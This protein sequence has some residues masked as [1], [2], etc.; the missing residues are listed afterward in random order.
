MKIA[1]A[2][3]V[4]GTDNEAKLLARCLENMS[5][6]VDGIFITRTHKKG[7]EPNEAVGAVARAYNAHLSDFEWVNDFA[8]ARNFNFSQVPAEYGYIMW[9]DA[10]DLWRGLGKLRATLQKHKSMDAFGFWYL[11]DWDEFKKPIVVHKKT[12]VIK[13]DGCA[14]WVGALHEDLD[15]TR[16][17]E[18][19]LVEGIDRLHISS[20]E[21]A[22]ENARRNVEIAKHQ[23]KLLPDDPRSYWNLG[24]S[25][26]GIADYK[27][28][29]RSFQHFIDT[30]ESDTEK[31]LVYMRLSDVCKAQGQS[32]E[33][34]KYLRIAIGLNPSI[35]DAYLQM[36]HLYYTMG[37]W[38]KAEHYCLEGLVK[39]PLIHS[40]IVYNPRDYDYNP[41]MLLARIYY[42]KNR[43]DLMLPMLKG[44]LKI[45]PDD[46]KLKNLV[47]EG[48]QD[49]KAMEAALKRVEKLQSIT[50]KE[51]LRKELAKLPTSIASH[52][53]ISVLRNQN[54]IKETS[55]GR[56]F[57]FYCGNTNQ[58]WNPETFKTEGVGGSEEAVINLS[59]ELAKLG[60]NV[61]VY[62][63]CGNR[64]AVETYGVYPMK[65]PVTITYRPFWEFN[66]RDKQDVVILWRWVKPLDIDIN[67]PKIF[68]DLHDVIPSGEF[69]EKRLARVSKI[70]V[71]TQFHRSLFPNV[72]DDKIAIIPNGIDFTLLNT[73]DIEKD[74]YLMINT[75]SP[76]R[77]MDVLPKLFREVKK[78]VP[79]ARLQWAYGWDGFKAAHS[80][81]TKKMKWMRDTQREMEDAGIETLGRITQAE[82]GKLY[83]RAAI[84]AYPTEF[85][86]IDCISVK[87]AQAAGAWVVS[88]DFGALDESVQWGLKVHS[89]KTKETWNRPYQFHFGLEDE[90][91]QA[92]WVA[93]C[94]AALQHGA[95]H[96][97]PTMR[98]FEWSRI[99]ARW[100]DIL[101]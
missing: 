43:P 3:I 34:I 53:A 45:Y 39:R 58:I 68:V 62:N 16:Q 8:A 1:L 88:S 59:R 19:F 14:K 54:F 44:C 77:S 76:D 7:E 21:R 101:T 36:A 24:N 69:N 32:D 55:T 2:M 47:R 63:N 51:K 66:Y 78:R 18:T 9:S 97:R 95:M 80:G 89:T 64:A 27:A 30:S 61:T 91:A 31:Y 6:Y 84:F 22:A 65:R 26:L 71:K 98:E 23:A 79:Q 57:V 37:N 96:T 74:P 92:D 52:P 99:A 93:A 94:V 85:A 75:S 60:W 29:E 100:H 5:P 49:Y 82:V 12:M 11:Y 70:F 72:P 50:D 56:D 15:P 81:D 87:K 10:D 28:A 40:M 48:E 90:E 33:A 86:E 20:E 41:M 17:L 67:A 35:P 25:Q 46:K 83:Q 73:A 13:N 4:K 42:Q 38:D